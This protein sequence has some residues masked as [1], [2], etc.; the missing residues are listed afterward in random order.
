M[1]QI[2]KKKPKS[3][4][5]IKSLRIDKKLQKAQE[6]ENE[7][8]NLLL[9]GAGE[10]GKSTIFKQM[11][12]LHLDG[13]DEEEKKDYRVHVHSNVIESIQS[14]VEAMQS[15]NINF[16]NEKNNEN[17]DEILSLK[18]SDTLTPELAEII[19]EIWE[20][21][22]IMETFDLS[23]KFQL[24]DS[25]SY[26]LNKVKSL[27]Q[28]SYIPSVDDIL[29]VRVR[30]TGISETTFKYEGLKFNMTDVG[31]QRSER[32]K[33]LHCFSSITAVFFIAAISEYDQ[34]LFEETETP[35]MTESLMLFDE[36][37]NSRWFRQTSII[38]FLNKID[39]FEKKV[40]K[41]DITCCFPEYTGGCDFETARN[42][43]Q[44]KFLELNQNNDKIVYPYF[45]CATDSENV[46]FIFK[47]VKDTLF[48]SELEDL[49]LL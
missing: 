1:G 38:L 43:I 2:I 3:E 35:R 20:D 12:L 42:Y 14:L 48:Q 31:G 16:S 34:M 30:T 36:I 33:W 19:K 41:K 18:Y 23:H 5:E 25:A 24:I 13:F 11:K 37:C 39:I 47:A 49:G 17:C 4:E 46:S 29:N 10:S 40:Q 9:L 45:T 21:P 8:A 27:A 26:F 15:M 44:D 22:G 28:E 7:E 6:T 32:K